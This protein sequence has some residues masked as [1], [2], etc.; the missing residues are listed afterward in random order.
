LRSKTNAE[1]ME[2]HKK[3][4]LRQKIFNLF[5]S[6]GTFGGIEKHKEIKMQRGVSLARQRNMNILNMIIR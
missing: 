3:G 1:A 6:G 2:R 5:D 4:Q